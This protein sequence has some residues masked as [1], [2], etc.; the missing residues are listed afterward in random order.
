VATSEVSGVIASF[1]GIRHANVYGVEIPSTEGRAGMAAL[2][3][4]HDFDLKGFWKHLISQLPPYARPLFLRIQKD[5]D[6]TGTFKYSKRELMRQAYN[7]ATTTD[8]IYFGHPGK[9]SFIRLDETM[10]DSIQAGRLRF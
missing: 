3:A 5:I 10:F 1:P 4:E 9:D 6:V 2:V 7:P 8:A